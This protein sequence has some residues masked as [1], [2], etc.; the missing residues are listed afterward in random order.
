M[1]F[2]QP[3]RQVAP[4]DVM[5]PTGQKALMSV[6]WSFVCVCVCVYSQR[7]NQPKIQMINQRS[8]VTQMFLVGSEIVLSLDTNLGHFQ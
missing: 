2:H 6:N 5:R 7:T 1:E 4:F 3:N 8:T